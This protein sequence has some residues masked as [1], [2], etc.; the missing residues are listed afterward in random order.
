MD[1]LGR[2]RSRTSPQSPCE[3]LTGESLNLGSSGLLTKSGEPSLAILF[4][5]SNETPKRRSAADL[6]KY[7]AGR[8][9]ARSTSIP[10]QLQPPI[11]D[12]PLVPVTEQMKPSPRMELPRSSS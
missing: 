9:S 5:S 3:G 12:V 11:S 1:V 10:S 4:A 8:D 6:R 2:Y 7:G